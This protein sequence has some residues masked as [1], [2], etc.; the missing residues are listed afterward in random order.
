MKVACELSDA[1]SYLHMSNVVYRDL[2]PV[3]HIQFACNDHLVHKI[4]LHVMFCI[5]TLKL[6]DF[7][8]ATKIAPEGE[9]PDESNDPKLLYDMCGTLRYMAAEVRSGHGYGKEVDV[10]SFGILLW[11]MCALKKPFAS[12]K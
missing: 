12:V 9:D 4:S 5:G 7:G 11:E 3:S 6:F 2:K 8:F 1:L 10:Y